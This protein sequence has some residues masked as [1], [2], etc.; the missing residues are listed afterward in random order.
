MGEALR[1]AEMQCDAFVVGELQHRLFQVIAEVGLMCARWYQQ[2]LLSLLQRDLRTLSSP[3][4][5]PEIVGNAE[6]PGLKASFVAQYM[7]RPVGLHEGV[8]G[9]VVRQGGIAPGE[10]AQETT[11]GGLMATHEFPKG[12]PVVS[13]L[14]LMNEF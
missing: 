13:G 4:I 9:E 1:E 11:H 12:S 6:K 7:D 3:R 10:L 5:A 14:H 8:L 2:P